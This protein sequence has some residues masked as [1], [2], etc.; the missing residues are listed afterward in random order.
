M[1]ARGGGM[2][3]G[4]DAAVRRG[5]ATRTR[6]R[7]GFRAQTEKVRGDFAATLLEER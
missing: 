4:E 1:A 2:L 6:E 7:R 5:G 3:R